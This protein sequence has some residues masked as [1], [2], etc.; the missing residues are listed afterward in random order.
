MYKLI[1][2]VYLILIGCEKFWISFKLT[3]I[4]FAEVH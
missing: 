2:S 3:L 1:N 4:K